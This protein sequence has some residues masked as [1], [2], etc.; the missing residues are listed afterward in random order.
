MKDVP[1]TTW[2]AH[3]DGL[4]VYTDGKL[5]AVIPFEQFGGVIF[6]LAGQM[7]GR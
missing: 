6:A 3:P 1:L 7:R 2:H 4:Y 5:V